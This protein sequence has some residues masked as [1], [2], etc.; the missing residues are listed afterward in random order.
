VASLAISFF[1]TLPVGSVQR[2]RQL[3]G[4][5]SID[6]FCS[7][8]SSSSY[9][10]RTRQSSAAAA[11]H[12]GGGKNEEIEIFQFSLNEDEIKERERVKIE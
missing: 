8:T 6:S 10:G 7:L 9:I 2:P 4:V 5:G 11:A 12:E 1:A 3:G